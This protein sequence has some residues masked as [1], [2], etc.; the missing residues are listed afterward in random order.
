MNAA[1]AIQLLIGLLAQANQL[2]LLIAKAQAE[3]RDITDAELDGLAAGD[4]LAR[5][6]LQAEIDRLRGGQ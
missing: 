4:D 5:A 6:R 3:G 2:G 1:T